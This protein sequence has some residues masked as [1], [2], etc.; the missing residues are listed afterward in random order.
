MIRYA[1]P[2]LVIAAAFTM[3][4]AAP[5]QSSEERQAAALDKRLEGLTPGKSTSC[6]PMTQ[7][8]EVKGY[9]G[10]ILYIQGKNRVWRNDT[11]G[12]CEGLGR[13][14]DVLVTR[15]TMGS[16]CRGDIVETHSRGGGGF[17]TGAC[18]LGEF[19]PYTK[20]K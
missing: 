3:T 14:D 2:A 12:G 1:M 16:Y 8:T 18:S 5:Y 15:T 7:V 13:S 10:T 17:M 4:A 11:N 19:T 20:A 6:V 9:N